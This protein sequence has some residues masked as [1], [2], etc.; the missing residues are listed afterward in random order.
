ML[1]KEFPILEFDPDKDAVIRPSMLL[2]KMDIVEKC[3][4]CF[5]SEAIEKILNEFTH[6]IV[7]HLVGEGVN[8]PVY[9]LEYKDSKLLL[10]QACIGGPMAAMQIEE[11]TAL[12]CSKFII[13]GG[14][15]VLQKDISVGNMIIPT[16]A[17]R[18]EGASYHYVKPSREI[19]ANEKVIKVIEETLIEHKIPYI[20]GKTWTTDAFYRETPQKVELRKSEGCIT[21]DMEA[22]VYMAVAQYNNVDIGQLLYAGD[23]LAGDE[24]DSRGWNSRE[25]ARELAL[26]LTLDACVKL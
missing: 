7:T 17:V 14:C 10:L 5:F 2:Q 23:S 18:D 1:K 12:G 24:W 3:V 4:L 21:V 26:R 9:E 15:G 19:V 25:K 11:L 6:R 16:V 22:S 8:I 20:K 13:C